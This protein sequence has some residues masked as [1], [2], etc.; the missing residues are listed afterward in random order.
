MKICGKFGTI[1]S[2]R[3]LFLERALHALRYTIAARSISSASCS[4]ELTKGKPWGKDEFMNISTVCAVKEYI[5]DDTMLFLSAHTHVDLKCSEIN[6]DPHNSWPQP[7][8]SESPQTR[9]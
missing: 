5:S 2:N 9:A 4:G 6:L 7:L 1:E 8:K 3:K